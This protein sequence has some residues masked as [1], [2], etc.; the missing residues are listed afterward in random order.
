MRLLPVALSAVVLGVSSAW[1]AGAA[2]PAAGAVTEGKLATRDGKEVIDVPLKHTEVKVHIAGYL[3]DVEVAQT[4]QNPYPRKIE[5]VY[6]FP[7]PTGA[8]V[9]EMEIVSSGRTWKGLIKRK[10]D[11]KRIYVEAKKEGH[12]AA[13]LVQERPNLFT[14]QVANI[15]PGAEVAVR[16]RYQQALEYDSGGYEL[17]FPMVAGPRYLPKTAQAQTPTAP[18]AVQP[19]VLPPGLRSSHD[20]GLEVEL[21]AGVP[22]TDVRSPSHQIDLARAG[23]SSAR[24]KLAAG[25]TIPNQDF[26]LRYQVAGPQPAFA[27]LTHREP[28]RD[29]SF[30]LMAQPPAQAPAAQVAPREIIFVLDTSS[31]MAG[32]PLDKAKQLVRRTLSALGPDDTFQMIRFDDAASALGPRPIANKPRNLRYALQWLDALEAGGGTEMLSGLEAALGV[33]HDPARLRIMVFLTDGYIGNEDEIL[34]AVGRQ[35]GDARLFSFGVGTAVNR[36]LLEEMARIGRGAVQVVRPDEDTQ[37]AVERFHRRI[38]RPLLTDLAID[39]NGLQVADLSPTAPPDLFVGQPIVLVGHY[40]APGRATITVRGRQGGREVA[41]QVPV[42]LP[43][44]EPAQPALAS[45]WARARIADLM[46]LQV[47]GERPERTEEI[48]ELALAHHLMSAYTAFVVVDASRVTKGGPAETVAVPVE[49]PEGVRRYA[50]R[51]A[52]ASGVLGGLAGGEVG[53]VLGL[54]GKGAGGGGAHVLGGA[55]EALEGSLDRPAYSAASPQP[56]PPVKVAE[57]KIV[58][59]GALDRDRIATLVHK[60]DIKAVYNDALKSH[61]GF[62]GRL[63]LELVIAPAGAVT[64]ARIVESTFP[65]DDGF[66]TRVLAAAKKWKFPASAS[67]ITVRLP[68]VF[69]APQ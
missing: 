44:L 29:G 49:V 3:A 35:L 14:Q 16:L 53:G 59:T 55:D 19:A 37:A 46:G 26:I 12:V 41:F 10:Q 68:F 58:I 43:A 63:V 21:E 47:R 30:L 23:A 56:A 22:I 39:W 32:L 34:A 62:E 57:H 25:D 52:D 8:A 7:L 42:T 67:E 38:A 17:V 66:V 28:G 15:E 20:I 4:F 9:S 2:S 69:K 31:S 60:D 51:P 50:M 27:V 33:P 18:A 13:L 61:P 48:T 65:K 1:A 36:Y 54:S 24:L 45:V 5:A 11:A 64:A 40:K 6:L